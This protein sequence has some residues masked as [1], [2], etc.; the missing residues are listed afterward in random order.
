MDT[1]LSAI[2]EAAAVA[3]EDLF[4]ALRAARDA[5]LRL[6][7]GTEL[8][9]RIDGNLHELDLL[10]RRELSVLVNGREP[11]PGEAEA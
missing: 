9:A 10:R 4:E 3:R 5:M 2:R 7:G 1:N 11:E 6:P 8:F